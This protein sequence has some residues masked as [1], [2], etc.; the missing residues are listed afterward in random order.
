MSDALFVYWEISDDDIEHYK[1][2]YGENFFETTRP[3]LV[4]YNETMNYSFE[5]PINDFA[6]SWYLHVNDAKCDYFFLTAAGRGGSKI[7]KGLP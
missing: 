3:V 7:A 1:N 2:T 4:V 6:N 5:I